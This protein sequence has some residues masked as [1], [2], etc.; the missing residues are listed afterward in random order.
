MGY[1]LL[2]ESML[3]SVLVAR[4]RFLR[5]KDTISPNSK[6]P[7]FQG[8]MVPS[9]TRMMLALCD[10]QAILKQ[11][12]GFWKD[13]YGFDMSCMSTEAFEEA[14][15]ECIPKEEVLSAPCI[16]KVCT[17]RALVYIS[18]QC[19][20]ILTFKLSRPKAFPSL[21]PSFSR[22]MNYQPHPQQK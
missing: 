19:T 14:I 8:V 13:V 18:S 15:V 20:R 17:D 1:A 5:P 2:Y 12:V 10:P 21:L 6:Q 11:R 3:D 7:E 9:Q 16:V 4:D 22:P